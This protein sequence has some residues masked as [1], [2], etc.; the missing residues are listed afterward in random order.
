MYESSETFILSL[1]FQQ[2]VNQ[3]A[4]NFYN[5]L[6]EFHE[7][8]DQQIKHVECRLEVKIILQTAVKN[9]EVNLIK[10]HHPLEIAHNGLV[11]WYNQVSVIISGLS[12]QPDYPSC[13]LINSPPTSMWDCTK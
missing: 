10:K 9:L 12:D 2:M 13:L 11:N 3:I 1:Q 8:V 7:T 4:L 5:K 6:S